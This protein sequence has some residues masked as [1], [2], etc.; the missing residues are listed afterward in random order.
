MATRPLEAYGA[1]SPDALVRQHGKLVRA[2]AWHVHGRAR[3]AVEIED[4]IQIGMVALVEASRTYVDRGE[5]SFGTYATMRVRGAMI[6]E[7]RRRATIGRGA[8][9]LKRDIG[10]ARA[11]VER[12]NARPADDAEVAARL[13]MTVAALHDAVAT[14]AS[15]RHESLDDAYSDHSIW[16]AAPD[17]DA[18]DELA[19]RRVAVALTL[20]IDKLPKREA[21]VLQLY[22]TEE[23]NLEEI[24]AVLGVGA[25]RVCQIKKA[26]LD[27]LRGD[28]AA[29]ADG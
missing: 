15:A 11:E 10:R 25:A 13:G 28:M 18:F 8:M 7:L 17:P 14:T 29:F 3:D 6:D 20:A 5:A 21:T 12:E 19:R 4:L 27:K 22:F 26:A 1:P 9:R 24:G 2:V 16:F 23:L